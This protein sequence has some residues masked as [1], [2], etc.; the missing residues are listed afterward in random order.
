MS[1]KRQRKE[2]PEE[3]P[4]LTEQ[5]VKKAIDNA[6]QKFDKDSNGALDKNEVR[7]LLVDGLKHKGLTDG[8]LK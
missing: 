8:E 1:E 3:D 6:Y 2:K 7:A 5:E 4:H